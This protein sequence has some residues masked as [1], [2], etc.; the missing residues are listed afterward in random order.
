MQNPGRGNLPGIGGLLRRMLA[1]NYK[2][3]SIS[4]FFLFISF[5]KLVKRRT[6]KC[7][8]SMLRKALLKEV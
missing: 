6:G 5:N 2:G 7:L 3:N 1:R 4:D 8:Y